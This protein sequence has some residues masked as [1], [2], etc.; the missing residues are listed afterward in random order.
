MIGKTTNG[1]AKTPN[2]LS[3]EI[4]R[5]PGRPPIYSH[6]RSLSVSNS[7][8][9]R[10]WNLVHEDPM[11]V[12]WSEPSQFPSPTQARR[13]DFDTTRGG[14]RRRPDFIGKEGN[15]QGYLSP[16]HSQNQVCN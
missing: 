10:H 4:A 9:G 15:R 13:Q 6:L 2:R 11:A 12:A 1:A 14:A 3:V 5:R 16:V 8:S 7:S